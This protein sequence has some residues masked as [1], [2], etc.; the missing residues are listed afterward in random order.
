MM[1][2]MVSA[3]DGGIVMT[4]DKKM[5]HEPQVLV[6]IMRT[7]SFITKRLDRTHTASGCRGPR[8]IPIQLQCHLGCWPSNW[9]SRIIRY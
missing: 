1:V 6:E 9:K 3:D 5:N 4:D 7:N 8:C 2:M